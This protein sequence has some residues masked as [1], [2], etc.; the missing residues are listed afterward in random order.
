MRLVY[1]HVYRG[2]VLGTRVWAIAAA[3]TPKN[4][5]PLLRLCATVF[6]CLLIASCAPT[7]TALFDDGHSGAWSDSPTTLALASE[8]T[9]APAS[10]TTAPVPSFDDE[11]RAA[12]DRLYRLRIACGRDPRAC[13]VDSLA[14]PASTYRAA[15]AELMAF[16]SRHGLATVAGYG[17]LRYRVEFITQ[18]AD[19]SVEVHT[20][21]TDSLVV[22]DTTAGTPGIVFDDRTVSL[23]TAWTLVRHA[24]VW[25]W[26]TQIVLTRQWKA[27]MCGDF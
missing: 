13:A 23:R 6:A 20:C 7:N 11:I 21:S 26:S 12:I 27:G 14:A 5:V 1:S 25:K 4:D 10:V 15:L 3:H 18:H 2:V 16:R 17:T 9:R 24:G 19:D 8:P 22:F